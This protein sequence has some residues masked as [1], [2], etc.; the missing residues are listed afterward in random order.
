MRISDWSSDVCSS[1]LSIGTLLRDS[2]RQY[3][4]ACRIAVVTNHSYFACTLVRDGGGVALIE[5]F[6]IVSGGFPDLVARPFRP[7]I[8]LRPRVIML[9]SRPVSHLTRQ[10]IDE[11]VATTHELVARGHEFLRLP[12]EIGRAHV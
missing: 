8:T 7:E 12:A 5:P 2:F 9:G 11:I 3:N 4:A 10:F 1:D 6:P